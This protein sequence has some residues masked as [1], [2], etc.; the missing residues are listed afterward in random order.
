MLDP[1]EKICFSGD[2]MIE[3]LWM[4]LEESLPPGTCLHS[5]GQAVKKLR[6]AGIERIYN[7]HY[8]YKP[9]TI[10]DTDI[11]LS[12]MQ[13]ICTGTAQGK[14]FNNTVGSGIEYTFG[15]WSVLCCDKT[16]LPV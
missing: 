4:F 13:Q 6:E 11:T 12:G 14:P 5:L 7:G 1:D 16:D 9:L 8:A 2:A 10:A 3:H 15:D